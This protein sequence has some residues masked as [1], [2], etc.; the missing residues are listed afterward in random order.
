MPAAPPKIPHAEILKGPLPQVAPPVIQPATQVTRTVQ[1]PQASAL[2]IPVINPSAPPGQE[3]TADQCTNCGAGASLIQR[4]MYNHLRCGRCG[5]EWQGENLW[6]RPVTR[7][8]LI[9]KKR[10]GSAPFIY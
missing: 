10:N 1:A 3:V 5:H 6:S 7:V 4:P 8:D 2:P 9:P